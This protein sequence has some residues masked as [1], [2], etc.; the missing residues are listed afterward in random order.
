MGQPTNVFYTASDGK[1]YQMFQVVGVDVSC[2]RCAFD[3]SGKFANNKALTEPCREVGDVC[4][5]FKQG[6]VYFKEAVG[7]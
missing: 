1:E 2:S 6:S 7:E 3:N 4:I 5:K